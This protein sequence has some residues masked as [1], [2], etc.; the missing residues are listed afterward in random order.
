MSKIRVSRTA[1]V[2]AIEKKK[3]KEWPMVVYFWAIGLALVSYV[4][5]RI[6]LDGSPH[7]YHWGTGIAGGLFGIGIGWLW[8]RWRGDIL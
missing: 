7:P 3:A 4:V 1:A 8:Y 5:A 2:S 6:V